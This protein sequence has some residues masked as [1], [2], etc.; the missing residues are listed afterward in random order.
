MEKMYGGKIDS[1]WFAHYHDYILVYAKTR[2]CGDQIYS[3]EAKRQSPAIK[4]L[5]MIPEAHGKQQISREQEALLR[6]ILLLHQQE[7]YFSLLMGNT[8]LR[9][10]K[11]VKNYLKRG[12]CGLVLMVIAFHR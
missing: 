5:I 8:G 3:R 9:Q 4:T 10:K 7:R 1:K 6:L 11:T 12:D 2:I